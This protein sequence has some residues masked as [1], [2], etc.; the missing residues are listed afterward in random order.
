MERDDIFTSTARRCRRCGGLLTSA[1]AIRDGYGRTCKMK[2]H[3]EALA[4]EEM[5][6]Q[7]SLFTADTQD[8]QGAAN[9][10][11][12]CV[13]GLSPTGHCGAA[14]CCAEPH[15]CCMACFKDCNIR[16]GWALDRR[17]DRL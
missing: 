4:R 14:A 17:S 11:G 16:C 7:M 3:R 2:T 13:T 9:G 6:N 8:T 15:D 12:K 1:Q 5:K 10:N